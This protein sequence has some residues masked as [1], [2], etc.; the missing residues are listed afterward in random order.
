MI[1][2]MSATNRVIK[3]FS[4]DRR[5]LKEVER[6]KG[7]NSVSERVNQLLLFALTAERNRSLF[8]EAESFFQQEDD[9]D[10]RKA[11]QRASIRSISR[12]EG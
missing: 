9:L 7:A 10:L 5:V 2:N 11:F 3:S 6:T 4:L 8:S 12:G 1:A